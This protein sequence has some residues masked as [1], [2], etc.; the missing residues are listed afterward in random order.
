M[1]TKNPEESNTHFTKGVSEI[2]TLQAPLRDEKD[3]GNED[4]GSFT[5]FVETF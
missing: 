5:D 1:Q 2:E 4:K 3:E